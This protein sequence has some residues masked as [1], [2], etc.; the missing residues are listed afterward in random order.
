MGSEMED[1]IEDVREDVEKLTPYKTEIQL[2]SLKKNES[3]L[4]GAVAYALEQ[5]DQE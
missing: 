4:R 1:I 5:I 3:C 2:T